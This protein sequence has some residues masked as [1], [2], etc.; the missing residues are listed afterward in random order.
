MNNGRPSSG[1]IHQSVLLLRRW[2]HGRLKK[3]EPLWRVL[4]RGYRWLLRHS[5][6]SITTSSCI[7]GY[8]PFTLDGHFAFSAFDQWGD[9]HNAGFVACVEACRGAQCVLDIGAHIG[10]VA[11]PMASVVAAG[12]QVFAFEP[13]RANHDYL[14]RHVALNQLQQTV[15]VLNSLVGDSVC[16][17]VPFF[18]QSDVA[19][20]NA[21]V[22]KKDADTYQETRRRQET[23][24]HF[25][26]QRSLSP[27]VIKI[28]VEGYELEVLRGAAATLRTAWPL[29]FLS[30][31]PVPI[32]M[33]GHTLEELCQLIDELGYQLL[34]VV[35]QQPV[36][37]VVMGEYLLRRRS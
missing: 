36:T 13:A 28:D 1:L 25:C 2:R 31:H 7:G 14:V 24:D 4:G 12:G 5:G 30:V 21:V 20:M 15:T 18:E 11:L 9:R 26:Q 8:G 27:Q 3:L 22:I 10:L 23:I 34:D 19:G 37:G 6:R 35:Q 32:R 29:V 33:L 17:E 16:E